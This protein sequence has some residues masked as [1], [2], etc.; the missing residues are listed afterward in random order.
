MSTGSGIVVDETLAPLVVV[1]YPRG[2]TTDEDVHV[3]IEWLHRRL[4][5]ERH[6]VQLIETRNMETPVSAAQRRLIAASLE[7][8]LYRD[9]RRYKLGDA[10]VMHSVL[11]RGAFGAMPA[12]AKI[13]SPIEIFDRAVDTVTFL[14]AHLSSVGLDLTDAMRTRIHAV[15]VAFAA[16]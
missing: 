3:Y 12:N 8:P 9:L 5:E 6:F 2:V 11:V 13:V 14:G 7:H 15:D 10:V 1:T 16:R 4:R